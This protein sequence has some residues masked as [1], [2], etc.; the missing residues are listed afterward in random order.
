MDE[1]L[2]VKLKAAITLS[3]LLEYKETIEML[4][5]ELNRI[6]EIYLKLM[7]EIECEEVFSSLE[8]IV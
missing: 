4:Q 5:P 6:L 2:P 8:G 7:N 1:S 3:C